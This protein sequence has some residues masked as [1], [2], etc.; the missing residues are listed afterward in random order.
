DL[1]AL[2]FFMAEQLAQHFLDVLEGVIVAVPK[3]HVVARLASALS[4]GRLLLYRGDGHGCFVRL[5]LFP[6]HHRCLACGKT[7][8]SKWRYRAW[9]LWHK[10]R[11]SIILDSLSLGERPACGGEGG[12]LQQ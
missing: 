3:K 8:L 5:L 10:A 7:W 9:P 12:T 2:F 4:G 11:C 6:I 1:F